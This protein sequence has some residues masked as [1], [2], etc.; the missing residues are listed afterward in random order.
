MAS[1]SNLYNRNPRLK[2][3]NVIIPFTQEQRD[4]WI[5]CSEDVEY[6]VNNYCMIMH[7]DRGLIPFQL[8]DYQKDMI[9]KLA[10][11]RFCIAKM[12][13]QT[14][15]STTVTAYMLWKILFQDYQ[16]CAIL[17]NK[18]RLARDLLSKIKLAYENL[19]MW[20]QQGVVVWNKNSI[21]LENGSKVLASATS[22]S[23]V[24]GSSFSMV[25]LDEFAHVEANLAED[26][27]ASVYPTIASGVKTQ[28]VVVSTPLG[29]NHFYKMWMDA[30]EGRSGYCPIEVHWSQVPGRDEEWKRMTIATSS[31][32]L[33]D[34]EH[35][36]HFLGSSNTLISGAKLR[37][38]TW[39][40]PIKDNWRVDIYEQPKEGRTYTICVDVSH[41][42]GMDY[43]AFTVMDITEVPFRLVAKFYD[44]QTSPQMF[45]EVVY[46]AAKKYNDAYVLVETND[47]GVIV[48]DALYRDL[49][50]ENVLTT[51]SREKGS[52]QDAS[53][54]FGGRSII[55]I[56]T[57]NSVKRVGCANLKDLIELDKVLLDDYDILQELSTFVS[58]KKLVYE[59]E[60]GKHDDLVMT[61]VLF[62]WLV[63]QDYFKE[64]TDTDVRANISKEKHKETWEDIP[65]IGYFSDGISAGALDEADDVLSLG[66]ETF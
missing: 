8:Y 64:L 17:A 14:G 27:F 25:M 22:S 36:T 37:S 40:T 31:E 18:E 19:P 52:R 55:G 48:A 43:S 34:Q 58:N 5:K 29:M 12:A 4:E 28:L 51:V 33:F 47:V 38:M 32:R 35:E 46:V 11:N 6:F 16:N 63:K 13:R 56:K 50:Y 15:K 23:A 66:R 21:E 24:R 54:G 62:G 9:R 44:N 2:A 61:L 1:F 65:P 41:G 42:V 49:E 10:A 3:A 57:T 26:F 59:A 60:E 20:L 45:P 7:V 30:I 53:S 39:K